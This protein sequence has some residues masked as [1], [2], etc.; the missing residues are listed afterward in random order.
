MIQEEVNFLKDL[1]HKDTAWKIFWT[2][3]IGQRI[4]N[5]V[6]KVVLLG[7][8]RRGYL[9][10]ED[11]L[12]QHCCEELFKTIK[13]IDQRNSYQR[14]NDLD[15]YL[16]KVVRNVCLQDVK[17]AINISKKEVLKYKR[18]D[19]DGDTLVNIIEEIVDDGN[20]FKNTSTVDNIIFLEDLIKKAG[21]SVKEKELFTDILN[22]KEIQDLSKTQSINTIKSRYRRGLLKIK[23]YLNKTDG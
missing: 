18:N 3:D 7:I 4:K 21:L 17:K 10:N 20:I 6:R 5:H 1:L 19:E 13:T 22:G 2:T 12:M 15:M 9:I 16:F 8:K 14:I 11:D 23:N